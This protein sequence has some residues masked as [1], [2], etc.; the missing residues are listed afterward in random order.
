MKKLLKGSVLGLVEKMAGKKKYQR[1]FIILNNLAIKGLNLRN[2]NIQENGELLIIKQISR[3]Y[4]AKKNDK[5][6]LFDVGANQGS[7]SETLLKEFHAYTTELYAF[8]PL[9]VPFQKLQQSLSNT[10]K[11]QASAFNFGLGNQNG[12]VQF[13]V[14][15]ETSE[16]GSIFKRD[17]SSIDIKIDAI[18][19][20][21]LRRADDFCREHKI[22][23]IHF[24]KVDVEGAEIEVFKG[25]N[26]LLQ[27][28]KIDFI[29][30]EFGSGNVDSKTYMSDF[31][32]EIG[33]KYELFRILKDGIFPMKKYTGDYEI[34]VM[35]NY[36]A[37]SKSL[38]NKNEEKI[39]QL[40]QF[41]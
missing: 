23:H 16:L 3:F 27:N 17:L 13:F 14:D 35:G 39:K 32:K 25:A 22:E 33:N 11:G 19:E 6:V 21:E 5:Y 20:I 41:Q 4:A 18:G 9:P 40:F 24:M 37:I 34:L 28:S 30:F 12:K 1:F 8:E 31:F 38:L 2:I 26:N 7:Y 29:Q 36:F 10:N 15:H